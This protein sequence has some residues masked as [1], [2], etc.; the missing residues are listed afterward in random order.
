M[1]IAVNTQHLLKDNLEGIG[2]FAHETLRRIVHNNPGHEFLFIFDR[3]WDE[4]F[5]YGPNVIPIST[6]IPSRHP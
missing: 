1:R 6:A 3:K 5:L 4:S 2:W